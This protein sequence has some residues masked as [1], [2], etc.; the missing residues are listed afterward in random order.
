MNLEDCVV[1]DLRMFRIPCFHRFKDHPTLNDRYL[2]LHLLG[3]GGFSEV[4]KVSVRNWIQRLRI[5]L[6]VITDLE[7]IKNSDNCGLLSIG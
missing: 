7:N 1:L 6:L 3:R 5:K 4:Y 2:L